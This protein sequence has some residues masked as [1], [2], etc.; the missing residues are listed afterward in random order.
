MTC[1]GPYET[2]TFDKS[3]IPTNINV[4]KLIL[5]RSDNLPTF[6]GVD[7]GISKLFDW[8]LF[9]FIYMYSSSL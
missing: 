8:A 3:P 5:A 1:D 9:A 4:N 6:E 7:S 2:F